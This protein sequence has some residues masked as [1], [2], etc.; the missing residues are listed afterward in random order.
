MAICNREQLEL[1]QR[2]IADLE[3]ALEEMKQEESEKA[4]Q[5]LSKG[6]IAQ[7]QQMRCEIDQYLHISQSP[8]EETEVVA[9]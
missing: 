1:T 3:L 9:G 4:Y 7:I 6:F 2:K 8:S 5:I